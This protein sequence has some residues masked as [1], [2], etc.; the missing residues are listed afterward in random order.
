[1]LYN[2]LVAIFPR[3]RKILVANEENFQMEDGR[4]GVEVEVVEDEW[5]KEAVS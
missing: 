5:M 1:M 4:H 3:D 2:I